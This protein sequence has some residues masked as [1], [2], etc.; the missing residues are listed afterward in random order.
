MQGILYGIGVGPGD[1]KLLTIKALEVMQ[2]CAVIA[3]AVS[4]PDYALTIQE[5]KPMEEE[6]YL[7]KCV[8]YQIAKQVFPEIVKKKK[9]YL[10]M[11]MTKESG[12]LNRC[13]EVAAD[14]VGQE[15]EKG[16]D[17]AFLTLGDP[18]IYSTYLYVH[19]RIQERGY[20]TQIIPGIPSFCAAAA[21]MGMGLVENREELHIIPASYDIQ[22]SLQLFGTKVFMKAGTK[23]E[24]VKEELKKRNLQVTMVENCGMV[25]EKSYHQVEDIPEQAGYYS[26]LIVK[27]ETK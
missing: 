20:Q 24:Q 14:M 15:L 7:E 13:H 8:A 27:E 22:D 21:R 4:D 1:P 26:L 9:C 16:R 25:N 19:K 6:R 18:T 3:I 23:L 10:P 5:K 17:V 11:P 2:G 12:L